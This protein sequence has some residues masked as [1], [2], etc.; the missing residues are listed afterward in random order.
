MI[1]VALK[2]IWSIEMTILV[3]GA[4][5]FIGRHLLARLTADG[6]PVLALMRQ[7]A[8]LDDLRRQVSR[9]GGDGGYV[10]CVRG[11]LDAP[12]LGLPAHLPALSTVIHLG[13]TFAWGLNPESARRTN[14]GGSLAV[15]ELARK[16]EARLVM[17]SGF[18][19]E[20]QAHL[21][22]L[23]LA[24]GLTPNWNAV[25]RKVGAYEASKLEAALRVRDFA[26][27]QGIDMV[28][29]QPATLS[30]HSV[31]GELDMG[32]PF[33]SLIENIA[34]GR[35]SM[36]PGSPA[37]WL[38]LVSV[39]ALA[40]LIAAASAAA[41]VP[42]RLLALDPATPNLGGLVAMIASALGWK[43]PTRHIPIGLL[44]A[45]LRIPGMAKAMNT[46]PESLHFLQPQRFDTTAT[47]AFRD[48]HGLHWPAI[49]Q[50]VTASTWFWR[51]HAPARSERHSAGHSR[52]CS[53]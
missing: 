8:K 3:T 29:V 26:K 45:V 13:A 24:A 17:I 35:L 9:L 51:D 38:P 14:V 50:S 40:S 48:T 16:S 20:N 15:A 42:R 5:G 39:D 27:D 46:A 21:R 10:A 30:G 36:I 11:D 41:E 25:Y 31:T 19:L 12:G 18:M 7:P 2:K 1:P 49:S 32:Q 33:W 43:P 44:R 4:T 47:D 22:G 34:H 37:H 28:E 53:L 52:R 6:R 23:G